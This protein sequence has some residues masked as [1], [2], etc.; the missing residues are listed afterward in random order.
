MMLENG[1]FINSFK[2]RVLQN[3][4]RRLDNDEVFREQSTGPVA[5]QMNEGYHLLAERGLRPSGRLGG[6]VPNSGYVLFRYT[7]FVEI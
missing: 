4:K 1:D 2:F 7:R 3:M 6:T 5:A